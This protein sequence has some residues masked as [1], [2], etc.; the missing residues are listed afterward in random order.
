MELSLL[1]NYCEHYDIP[2]ISQAT[3]DFLRKHI[4]A[5]KPCRVIE[6]GSA[7]WYSSRVIAEVMYEQH[8]D[9]VALSLL[10]R[11]ISYPH[12]RQAWLSLDQRKYHFVYHFLGHINRY[13]L[14]RYI[15]Q[16]YDMFFIDGRKSETL[17]YLRQLTYSMHPLSTIIIDDV[18]KFK[19]KMQETY[20]YLDSHHITYTIFPLDS[21]DGVM[22]IHGKD[23][24]HK[25]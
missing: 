3:E 1:R 25:S 15:I 11:E 13:P 23:R 24:L 6:V 19:N 22:L 12:Y 9:D 5:Y 7:V 10:S 18:I 8:K 21:D 2:L 20:D 17:D 14:E 4:Q 16:P